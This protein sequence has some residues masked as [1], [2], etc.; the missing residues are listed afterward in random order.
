M[1]GKSGSMFGVATAVLLVAI[2]VVTNVVSSNLFGRID[3]TEG[4]IYSLDGASKR[5]VGELDDT[6]LV[7]AYFSKNLPAPYN[8]NA[9][10]VQ[11]KLE[12]YRAY[13][14]GRFRFEFVDPGND[15]KLEEEAQKHR[16]PPVQVQVVEHDQFAAK[17]AYMG[18]VFLYQ[19]R[20]ETIPVVDNPVGLEYEI[21]TTIKKLTSPSGQLPALGILGGHR[22]PS[23][24]QLA[25]VQQVFAKQYQLRPVELAGGQRVAADVQVLLVAS[26]RS[27]FSEWEK[28]AI[29][30]FIMR[31]GK[32]A[33]L[34]DKVD[35]DLQT[36]RA[37]PV[38]LE[39]DDWLAAYGVRV[40]DNLIGDMQNPGLL[41]ITQQEG[42]FRMMSQVPYPFIPN[43]RDFNRD[44]VM[45]KDLERVGV[46][47]A[48]SIDTSV[49][50][51]R[52]LRTEPLFYSSPKSTVQ[53]QAYNINPTTRWRQEDFDRG[54]QVLAAVV[55]GP[56]TSY[57]KDK[58]VPAASDTAAVPALHEPTVTTSPENRIVVVG[59][60]EFFVDDKGGSD[61]DN[62]LFFQNLVDWLM[63]DE[64]LIGIR[65]R[66]VTDRPLRSVSPATKNIVKYAN[67]LGSPLLVVILGIVAWQLRR[68][69]RIEV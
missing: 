18:L 3:L 56:F 15:A 22:E 47:Y 32:V 20:Q 68:R 34:V 62:L 50:R 60:G 48:S 42:F 33:F 61:R 44:N 45:V 54:Q 24:Q 21:T 23:L 26:P 55:Y 4:N 9:K 35:A 57:F 37:M 41:T 17:R 58:P 53:E 1:Q 11:D 8:A 59:D 25:T 64:D 69:R 52:G 46:Y 63:Q 28:Y 43:L 65:S 2:L 39:L 19:D 29:D 14:K 6:F 38:R 7:K 27:P 36:Q 31:G 10:Y 5:I 16:I 12:E 66:E 49:A 51:A 30:Q 13:G 40:N 67:M